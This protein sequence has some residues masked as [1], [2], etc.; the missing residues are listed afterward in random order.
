VNYR[1][2]YGTGHVGNVIE[3][4]RVANRELARARK[5]CPEAFL[6]SFL[7]GEWFS[8]LVPDELSDWT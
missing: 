2:N 1:V 5:D 6:Q 8:M 3:G 4:R 7:D